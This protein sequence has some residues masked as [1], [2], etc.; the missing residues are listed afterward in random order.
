MHFFHGAM[1]STSEI[2][3][4][5]ISML[6]ILSQGWIWGTTTVVLSHEGA[7]FYIAESLVVVVVRSLNEG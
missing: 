5:V 3:R 1:G 4:L 2:S 6:Y 7:L